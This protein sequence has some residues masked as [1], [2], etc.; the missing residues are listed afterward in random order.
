M[1]SYYMVAWMLHIV[2]RILRANLYI[3]SLFRCSQRLQNQIY[4]HNCN[5]QQC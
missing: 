2:P 5:Y 3:F 1:G 4:K